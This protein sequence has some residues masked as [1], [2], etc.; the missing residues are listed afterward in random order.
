MYEYSGQ[1]IRLISQLPHE[2]I[3]DI[4]TCSGHFPIFLF[5]YIHVHNLEAVIISSISINGIRPYACQQTVK[6]HT[7]ACAE[8]VSTLKLK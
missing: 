4:A 8:Y 2:D 1:T 5:S 7:S 3:R 6:I